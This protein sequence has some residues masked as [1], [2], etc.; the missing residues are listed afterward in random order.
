MALYSIIAIQEREREVERGDCPRPVQFVHIHEP[1]YFAIWLT[2]PTSYPEALY[3][4]DQI[5]TSLPYIIF[6]IA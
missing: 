5:H 4:R 2:L 3:S 1:A 6:L